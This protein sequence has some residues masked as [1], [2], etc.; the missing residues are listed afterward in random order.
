MSYLLLN[1]SILFNLFLTFLIFLKCANSASDEKLY[2]L[3][4][5]K[6]GG[7]QLVRVYSAN[8]QSAYKEKEE[9]VR[10]KLLYKSSINETG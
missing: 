2:Y 1:M 8:P 4:A 6:D 9:N 7:D 3:V 5:G 10:A